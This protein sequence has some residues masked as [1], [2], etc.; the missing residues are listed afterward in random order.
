M[1]MFILFQGMTFMVE[2]LVLLNNNNPGSGAFILLD[3]LNENNIN[4]GDNT[5]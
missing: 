5:N 4:C 3:F 2:V 1:L